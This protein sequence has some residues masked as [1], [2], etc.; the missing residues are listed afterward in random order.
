MY[1]NIH[2]NLIV[3]GCNGVSW[4]VRGSSSL[5]VLKLALNFALK[6]WSG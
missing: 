2:V 6:L 4:N 3:P 5:A 1:T